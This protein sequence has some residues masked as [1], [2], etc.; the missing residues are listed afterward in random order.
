MTPADANA[1][2][3]CVNEKTYKCTP[4]QKRLKGFEPST[5]CMASSRSAAPRMQKCLQI[6]VSGRLDRTLAFQELCADTAGLD[7][8]RTMADADGGG[9][10]PGRPFGT[11]RALLA[12]SL[13]RLPGRSRYTTGP[14]RAI[15]GPRRRGRFAPL[16][17]RSGSD[18]G[19][20]CAD[21]AWDSSKRVTLPPQ[22]RGDRFATKPFK[23]TGA[24]ND[25]E[26]WI[27][28]ARILL[29]NASAQALLD[30]T[31]RH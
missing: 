8:E 10:A 7:N 1:P 24:E 2:T 11:R 16:G 23:Q 12:S 14:R 27:S 13:S 6:G 28:R 25:Q 15:P 18:A 3:G 31:A 26:G 20:Q 21:C 29:V 4:F 17:H 9:R 30:P 22:R 19:A 5:F